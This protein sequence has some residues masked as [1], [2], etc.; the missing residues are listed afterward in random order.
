MY[1]LFLDVTVITDTRFGTSCSVADKENKSA[2]NS[3]KARIVLYNM[4][5]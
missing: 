5:E 2:R 3:N 4:S 1:M